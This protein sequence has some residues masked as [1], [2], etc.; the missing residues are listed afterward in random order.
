MTSQ[1][2]KP[3]LRF[4]EFEENWEKKKVSQVTDR[5]SNPVD[6]EAERLYTQIGI[7]SHGKG[8]F[9]KDPVTGKELGNKRVFWVEQD[10]FVVNIVFAW[11]QAVAK[12][13]KY[14][15]GT[16]VSHRFPMFRPKADLLNLD[17]LLFSFLTRRGKSLLELAS[18]GGAGRNK[19]LGQEEFNRTKIN[20]PCVEEQ[21]KIAAFLSV[22]DEKI[23]Q[24]ARKKELLLK[25]KKGV[26]QQI[27]DQKLRFKDANGN[28]FPDWEGKKLGDIAT[29]S[30]GSGISKEDTASNGLYECIRY[31]ELYTHYTET[32]DEVVSRTNLGK[33]ELA[34]SE[35]NDVIIPSSGET[36]IDIARA[37]CILR[38]GIALGGDLT[39]IRS[40]LNGVFLSYYLNSK[41]KYDVA[42]LAQG[43]SVVHL[44]PNHLATLG[45]EI[46]SANE[47]RLIA[48]FLSSVEKKI[49]L[50][51]RQIEGMKTFKRGL[52]QQMFV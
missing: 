18:P 39:I 33:S 7:R 45:I 47:Q 28:D 35:E 31:G 25:Y 23:R 52:L 43:V 20:L 29:F 5:V 50:A 1:T 13:T 4:P 36:N 46:P 49:A 27:F 34:F 8:L 2:F 6:V 15:L 17:F 44:Y 14:E 16:I 40:S 41:K 32:I 19:T 48:D 10:L 51:T 3:R 38:K 9:H 42:R 30:K 21:R 26:M 24:L 12:T 37:A 11:E 22:V